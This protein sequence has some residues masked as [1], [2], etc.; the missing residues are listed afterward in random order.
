[1]ANGYFGSTAVSLC[2]HISDK[3]LNDRS[4]GSYG[5]HNSRA[6]GGHDGCLG[7]TK[8]TRQKLFLSVILPTF[9]F[10]YART[11]YLSLAR[12]RLNSDQ[13][14]GISRIICLSNIPCNSLIHCRP[15]AF[16]ILWIV[17]ERLYR[18]DQICV[19]C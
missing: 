17:P 6:N 11:A 9:P 8:L 7:K 3:S 14:F 16:A 1:M 4:S 5:C 10:G 12:I 13:K 18:S 15:A 2:P 19:N